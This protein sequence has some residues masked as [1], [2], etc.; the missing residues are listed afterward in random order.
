[1]NVIIG[2]LTGTAASMGLG[3][4]FIIL[5]YLSAFTDT[6]QDIAQGIN[7]LFFLPIAL[8]SIVIHIKNKLIDK[9]TVIRYI[10]PGIIGVL[11]GSGISLMLDTGILR[12]LFAGVI[13]IVGI[14][15]L[16]KKEKPTSSPLSYH[17]KP[18]PAV[19]ACCPQNDNK[20]CPLSH[21]EDTAAPHNDWENHG[22]RDNS[23]P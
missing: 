11:C 10:I 15:E 23:D 4:G 12:K 18:L 22:D 7:L 21:P 6:R 8:L 3:G 2:I 20:P 13:L 14:R 1:M 9:K 19:Q 16:F 17:D 5:I